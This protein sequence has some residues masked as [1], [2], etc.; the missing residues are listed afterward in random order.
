MIIY[1]IFSIKQYITYTNNKKELYR[2]IIHHI[3]SAQLLMAHDPSLND[4]SLSSS[5]SLTPTPNK[6]S[7]IDM[8][9]RLRTSRTAEIRERNCSLCSPP[10]VRRGNRRPSSNHRKSL[11]SQSSPSRGANLRTQGTNHCECY[12]PSGVP[13]INRERL[14]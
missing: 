11:G 8:M 4:T 5:T 10:C 9:P 6:S 7:D 3:I 1:I 2:Y 14:Y 13:I 12:T